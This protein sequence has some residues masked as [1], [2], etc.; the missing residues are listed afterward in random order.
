ML[1]DA[2]TQLCSAK[3]MAEVAKRIWDA[4]GGVDFLG[5]NREI[6][7]E[8]YR[9]DVEINGQT[10]YNVAIRPKGNTSLSSIASDPDN[11]RYSFKLEFDQYEDGQ[12][13]FGLDKLILNNNFA[14]AT[15]MKEALI[16][17]MFQYMGA[18]ASLYNYAEIS[19]NGE[20]WGVYLALEAVEESFLLR[21]YG[22]NY[23]ELYK[24]DSMQ[25]GGGVK[26]DKKNAG[27]SESDDSPG[28]GGF[29][30]GS[31]G[32]SNL[33][34]TDDEL[35]IY[36]T[37]W[38]SEITDTNKADH[39][40]VVEAL[41][42]I[43]QGNDL[44]SYMDTENLLKYA[45]V[46]IF[47]VNTD[48]LSGMMAHNYYLYESDGRLNLLPW[49]YNL[50]LGGMGGMG[51]P[52]GSGATATVNDPIDNAF[53][54]TRFFDTLLAD[55]TYHAQYYEYMLKLAG[56]YING[57]GFESFYTRTRSQ[58]DALV[59]T[60]PNALYSYEEYE[61]AA[62]ILYEVVTLRG[63]SIE[64]QVKGSIPSTSGEQNDSSALID[65]SHIDL[66]D[67]GT[68]SMGGGFDFGNRTERKEADTENKEKE[69]QENRGEMPEGFNPGQFGGEMPEGF[70]PK[71]F[72]GGMPE[73]FDPGQFGGEM[74]EDFNP[75]DFG[76]KMPG[77]FEGSRP[78]NGMSDMAGMGKMTEGTV[79]NLALYGVCLLVLVGGL[80]FALTFKRKSTKPKSITP[81][82]APIYPVYCI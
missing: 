53:S 36:S 80:V 44:L 55:E 12:S 27:R 24:P 22:T 29:G 61:A 54:G 73:G 40:R 14:D 34:Y 60:D 17:D 9:C 37:L 65:A 75:A 23:G 31:G 11:D 64:G 7:E 19:V 82:T 45:A 42:N 20:Y 1:G 32:G 46:H 50:S 8:Y 68:M 63:A 25:F 81:Q 28:K 76:G 38:E 78:D 2:V 58:I 56:E 74:P 79:Q 5:E 43:S 66:S 21:N 57:G 41:R 3:G 47:S 30:F 15:N 52:G 13:C 49:D 67:M 71:Q 33:N 26:A 72:G 77:G 4:S 48:S 59:E 70:D 69:M 62:E 18:D 51:G 10:F 16:Y 6:A 35:D 39:T